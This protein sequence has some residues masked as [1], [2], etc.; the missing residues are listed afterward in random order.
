[1]RLLKYNPKHN[2]LMCAVVKEELNT[3]GCA[4]IGKENNIKIL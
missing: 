1:M 4:V 3:S 2:K